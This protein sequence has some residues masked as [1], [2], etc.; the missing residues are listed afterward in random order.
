MTY[1]EYAFTEDDDI[2]VERLEIC[3]AIWILVEATETHQIVVPEK[4]DFLSRLLHLNILCGKR[5]NGENLST[6]SVNFCKRHTST[7]VLT[8]LSSLISSSVGERTSSHHVQPSATASP[9]SRRSLPNDF[10]VAGP[11]GFNLGDVSSE[12]GFDPKSEGACIGLPL[13]LGLVP[14]AA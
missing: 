6:R 12:P 4:L 2:H 1:R 5:M 10:D 11:T 9:G 13:E 3:R 7:N 8:L 14:G